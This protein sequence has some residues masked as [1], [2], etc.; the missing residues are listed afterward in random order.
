MRDGR[1]IG[2]INAST[3]TLII[4]EQYQLFYYCKGSTIN[5]EDKFLGNLNP[6]PLREPLS[7]FRYFNPQTKFCIK[8]RWL[9][10]EFC[11][12]FKNRRKKKD[13]T[14]ILPIVMPNHI[15]IWGL[16]YW[17][18]VFTTYYVVKWS[19]GHPLPLLL[20]TWFMDAPKM[21]YV[22][23]NCFRKKNFLRLIVSK[24]FFFFWFVQGFDFEY[25]CHYTYQSNQ[26][27]DFNSSELR[28][29]ATSLSNLSRYLHP[30]ILSES[31]KKSI[32]WM[33]SIIV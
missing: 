31:L 4:I 6:I 18:R 21:I 11:T 28:K 2:W 7:R 17:N 30:L 29:K 5:H 3:G 1:T 24:L 23:I 33:N 9:Y 22:L 8:I 15:R 27:I 20:S 10:I 25:V 14:R 12:E 19:F 13:I 32:F 26:A 16:K